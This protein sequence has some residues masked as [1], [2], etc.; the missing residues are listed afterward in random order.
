MSLDVTKEEKNA[1]T[2]DSGFNLCGI[3]YFEPLGRR[4][5]LIERYERYQDAL[6]A[7]QERENPNEYLILYKG[8]P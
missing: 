1:L 6:K 4:L 7:K 3:D 2:P 5:Y 8:A